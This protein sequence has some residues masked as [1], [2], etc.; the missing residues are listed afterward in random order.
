M[1]YW[2]KREQLK[3]LTP[4][5]TLGQVLCSYY[6]SVRVFDQIISSSILETFIGSLREKINKHGIQQ[7][8]IVLSFHLP[9]L[10]SGSTL[11]RIFLT[12]EAPP[13]G[14]FADLYIIVNHKIVIVLYCLRHLQA[15]RKYF[16]N[17]EKCRKFTIFLSYYANVGVFLK[18]IKE[19]PLPP[20][21]YLSSNNKKIRNR[22][23]SRVQLVWRLRVMGSWTL[24]V[25][26]REY[27]KPTYIWLSYHIRLLYLGSRSFMNKLDLSKAIK[28]VQK[29]KTNL[30]FAGVH[31]YTACT[32]ICIQFCIFLVY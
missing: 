15:A 2:Y 27:L 1:S 22:V 28:E 19:I 18:E 31:M 14:F 20:F 26:K 24:S 3:P 32:C 7:E 11:Y 9:Y 23:D 12:L 25:K 8:S 6:I 13:T 21:T 29:V 10:P 16:N 30:K 5:H 17:G 4:R